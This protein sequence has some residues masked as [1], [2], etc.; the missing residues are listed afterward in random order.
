MNLKPLTWVGFAG[1]AVW[2]VFV[3]WYLDKTNHIQ[4]VLTSAPNNFGDFWAGT[5]AP[6]AFWWLV[7]GYFQQG[8]ELRQNVEALKRQSEETGKLVEQAKTQ[9]DWNQWSA[10]AAAMATAIQLSNVIISQIQFDCLRVIEIFNSKAAESSRQAYFNGDLN[11][12]VRRLIM[13]ATSYPDFGEVITK[14][15]ARRYVDKVFHSYEKLI[16]DIVIGAQDGSGSLAFAYENG[17][18]GDAY[19]ALCLTT[20][21]T[22]MFNQ[23]SKVTS[24]EEI[25]V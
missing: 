18:L 10:N 1:T 19:A 13:M 22:Q 3:L 8:I 17:I 5:F 16:L 15:T 7:L 9:A 4:T 6:L 25:R 14:P 11:A 24:L 12:P 21:H 20:G 2:G 23:R